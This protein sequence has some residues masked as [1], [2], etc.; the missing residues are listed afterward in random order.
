[1]YLE[2]LCWLLCSV[3]LHLAD[4]DA[5][6]K[7]ASKEQARKGGWENVLKKLDPPL[8]HLLPVWRLY[9]HQTDFK[10]MWQPNGVGV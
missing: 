2:N 5:G 9:R 6:H 1:M 7:A 10:K 4:T 3:C 8:V